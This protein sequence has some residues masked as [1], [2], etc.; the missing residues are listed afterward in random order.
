[1]FTI[2][3]CTHDMK[4]GLLSLRSVRDSDFCDDLRRCNG[5][6][7][8]SFY[9]Q[10]HDSNHKV[11]YNGQMMIRTQSPELDGEPEHSGR[12]SCRRQSA[13][14]VPV[15]HTELTTCRCTCTHTPG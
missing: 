10:N 7:L 12:A 6:E 13:G 5:N 1:M 15:Q 4:K 11:G 3:I 14:T 8:A 9:D 2:H